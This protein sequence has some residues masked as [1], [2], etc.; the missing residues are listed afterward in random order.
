MDGLSL[1]ALVEEHLAIAR[2][3]GS[4][5]EATLQVLHGRVRLHAGDDAWEGAPG[6][7]VLIPPRRHDLTALEDAAVL[8]TVANR[9][10]E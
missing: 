7:Y 6:D 2:E 1:A 5:G 9:L 10:A 3:H 8:L 4:P